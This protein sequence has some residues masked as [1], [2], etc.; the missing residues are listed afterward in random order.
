[1]IVQKCRLLRVCYKGTSVFNRDKLLC[2]DVRKY[3]VIT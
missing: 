2:A 3:E 1:M